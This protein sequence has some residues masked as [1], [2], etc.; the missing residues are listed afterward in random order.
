MSQMFWCRVEENARKSTQK[1]TLLQRSANYLRKIFWSGWSHSYS[2]TR[3]KP[4]NHATL[5]LPLNSSAGIGSLAKQ[6]RFEAS[7]PSGWA[8]TPV[9]LC[10]SYLSLAYCSSTLNQPE[11]EKHVR[12]TGVSTCSSSWS[13]GVVRKSETLAH[14]SI[15]SAIVKKLD[16]QNTSEICQ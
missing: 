6:F 4:M 8:R 9:R 2:L 5:T 16:C 15:T 14:S 10:L 3:G 1:S 7:C 11:A 13:R 12:S